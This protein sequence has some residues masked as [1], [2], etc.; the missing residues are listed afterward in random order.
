MLGDA[1]ATAEAARQMLDLAAA[2]G[3]DD[4]PRLPV[5]ANDGTTASVA[6]AAPRTTRSPAHEAEAPERSDAHIASHSAATRTTST[7]MATRSRSA[8]ITRRSLGGPG[9]SGSCGTERGGLDGGGSDRSPFRDPTTKRANRHAGQLCQH[10][11][12][13]LGDEVG[14]NVARLTIDA[15]SGRR[16]H[17]RSLSI[18]YRGRPVDRRRVDLVERLR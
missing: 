8:G 15:K 10:A 9:R 2:A 4:L 11:V 16:L 1:W 12:A 5:E 18:Q 3:L 7:R 14:A 6:Y 13:V 17:N